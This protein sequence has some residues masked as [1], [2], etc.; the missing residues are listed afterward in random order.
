[1]RALTAAELLSVWEWGQAQPAVQ[2]AVMLLAAACPETPPEALAAL[3]IGQRDAH[4]LTLRAWTFGSQ[5][6]SVANCPRCD[7]RLELSFDVADIQVPA[8]EQVAILGL[9]EAGYAVEFR[10][11][12]S[13]DL[14]AVTACP[15]IATARALLFDRCLV[16]LRREAEPVSAAEVPA[17]VVDTVVA[18]MAEADP[19]ADVQLALTCPACAHQWQAPFDIVAFF[20]SEIGAWVPRLLREVHTLA[21]AYGWSEAAILAL[22]PWRRQFYLDMVG[23]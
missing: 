10:L 2:R 5:L 22:S 18:R 8:A 7:E 21:S 23:R 14:G 1:M 17:A 6:V 13:L 9:H 3:S 15:D 12:N 19:Q 11:P 20:W 4:L 16:T